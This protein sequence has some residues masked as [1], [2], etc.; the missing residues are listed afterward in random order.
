M[1]LVIKLNVPLL[2]VLIEIDCFEKEL[3]LV[4]TNLI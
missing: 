1:L 2:F 3:K 4:Q